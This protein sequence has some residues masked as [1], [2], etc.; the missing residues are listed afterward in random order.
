MAVPF[1]TERLEKAVY[2]T[3]Q[4]WMTC[5]DEMVYHSVGMTPDFYNTWC[6]ENATISIDKDVKYYGTGSL[7]VDYTNSEFSILPVLKINDNTFRDVSCDFS[8]FKA[9][10]LFVKT[11]ND[12]VKLNA[13]VF[14]ID[15][16]F[17]NAQFVTEK[18][19]SHWIRVR[20][21]LDKLY[22]SDG[23]EFLGKLEISSMVFNFISLTKNGT[24]YLDDF[25]FSTEK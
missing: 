8:N 14:K 16:C 25:S 1:R 17:V 7:K 6:A 5:D 20:I 10:T 13:V 4:H 18:T 21:I 15:N 12:I 3:N 9:L 24:I 23:S 22:N 2:F 11:I 19:E